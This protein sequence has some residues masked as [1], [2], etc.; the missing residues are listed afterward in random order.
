MKKILVILCICMVCFCDIALAAKQIK[1]NTEEMICSINSETEYWAV[2][3]C[4]NTTN[5]TSIYNSIINKSNWNESHIILLKREQA[6]KENILD[7]LEWLSI[8]TGSQDIIL[9][10][11]TGHGTYT[12]IFNDRKYGIVPWD[13][14]LILTD[15]LDEKLDQ[16]KCKYQCLFFDCC[17]S[18]NFVGR[19]FLFF[20]SILDEENRVILMS[21]QRRGAGFTAAVIVGDEEVNV[22]NFERFVSE[23]FQKGIDKNSDG[24]VSA[25]E[26]FSYGKKKFRPYAIIFFFFIPLQIQSFIQSRGFLLIPFPKIYDGVE[27]D[28]PLVKI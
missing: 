3:V 27:G 19:N 22:I 8:N 6:T 24:W 15:E 7:A 26:A 12:G 9:F 10:S 1:P 16:I 23:A 25:E 11:Y 14:N 18:G 5:I 28:L 17:L 2:I 4:T 20:S 21:T 13:H